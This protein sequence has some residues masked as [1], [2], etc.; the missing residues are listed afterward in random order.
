MNST[1]P[2]KRFQVRFCRLRYV[3]PKRREGE[4]EWN[5]PHSIPIEWA[6]KAEHPGIFYPFS[7][8]KGKHSLEMVFS[9]PRAKRCS[10]LCLEEL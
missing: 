6:D 5:S 10:F 4:W 3:V 2:F 9:S 1:H 7:S 8:F